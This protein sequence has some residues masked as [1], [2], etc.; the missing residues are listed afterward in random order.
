MQKDDILKIII[1]KRRKF[2]YNLG[3][4]KAFVCMIWNLETVKEKVDKF[5]YLKVRLNSLHGRKYS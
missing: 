2:L 4:S 1:E 3:A 5:S